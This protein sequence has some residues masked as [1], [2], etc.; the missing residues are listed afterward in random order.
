MYREILLMY[1][2]LHS[3]IEQCTVQDIYYLTLAAG[4]ILVVE[5][6]SF[7]G[8]R[9]SRLLKQTKN[10]PSATVHAKDPPATPPITNT[11]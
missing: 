11:F 7:F 3:M 1:A 10:D 6:Q 2:R 9:R 4:D 8:E 5:E